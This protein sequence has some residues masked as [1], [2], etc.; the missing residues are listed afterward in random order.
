MKTRSTLQKVSSYIKKLESGV[1][2][3]GVKNEDNCIKWSQNPNDVTEEEIRGV[4]GGF[5]IHNVLTPQEC[6]QFIDITENMG[7]DLALVTT[8]G[9]MKKMTDLRSNKRLIWDLERQSL[10]TRKIYDRIKA[11]LPETEELRGKLY[12]P[13]E[14]N[15]RL[16]FY[17]Y[18]GK[19]V[20]AR[21]YDGCYPRN[22]NEISMITFIIYLNDNFE[23]GAT[24]FYMEDNWVE[25]QHCTKPRQGSACIFYHGPHKLSPE[26]EGSM[27]SKGTKYVLRSDVMFKAIKQ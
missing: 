24:K 16:R 17:R 13:F 1:E 22:E 3:Y 2:I 6:E 12:A 27:C 7:Y 4:P 18:N 21:H 10:I 8:G 26:H 25:T 11:K 9:G 20:F 5:I 23:G 19:E 14:L 15:E